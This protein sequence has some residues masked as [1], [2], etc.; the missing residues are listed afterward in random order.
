MFRSSVRPTPRSAAKRASIMTRARMR[1]RPSA[2]CQLQRV[3]VRPR[4]SGLD[5]APSVWHNLRSRWATTSP[6]CKEVH[7]A[8]RQRLRQPPLLS[9]RA[10]SG[11]GGYPS[12]THVRRGHRVVRVD[13]ELVE[14]L[15]RNDLCPCG[16]GRR[17]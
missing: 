17:F 12:E 6:Y 2:L 16:S 9:T 5:A 15:G 3:V 11:G 1:T 13:K 8:K 14:K 7:H 4:A 10:V